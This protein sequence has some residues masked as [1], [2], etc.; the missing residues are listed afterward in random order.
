ML[1]RLKR[2]LKRAYRLSDA[3]CRDFRPETSKA[4]DKPLQPASG[5]P[6]ELPVRLYAPQHLARIAEDPDLRAALAADLT[7]DDADDLGAAPAK[8]KKPACSAM[9]PPAPRP[10]KRAKKRAGRKKR[11]GPNADGE[12]PSDSDDDDEWRK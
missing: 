5:G 8:R 11:K 4:H 10:V 6:L 12:W 1:G 2:H 9:A 7:F 3:K